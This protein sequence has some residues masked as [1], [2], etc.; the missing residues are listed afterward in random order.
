LPGQNRRRDD[1]HE[2][3]PACACRESCHRRQ[4]EAAGLCWCDIDLDGKTAV[5]SQQLQH[6]ADRL[7]TL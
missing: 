2:T 3:A 5:I 6:Y 1:N 7:A 4:K